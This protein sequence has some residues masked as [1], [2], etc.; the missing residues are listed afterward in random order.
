MTG[1]L[2]NWII[3][4]APK[5]S[6][7]SLF[8]WLVDHPEVGGSYEKE[9][10]YFLDPGAHMFRADSNFRDQGIKG[11]SK[12]FEHCEPSAAVIVESTPAYL[13]SQAALRELPGLPT[14]PSF[15][16]VLREPVSQLRSLFVYF[17]QNWNWIPRAMTFRE[18]ISAV[19]ERRSDFAGNELA[20]NALDNAWYSRHLLRWQQAV[21]ADRMLILLFEDLVTDSRRA[22][23][24]LAVRLGIDPSFYD[25]YAFEPEN[26]SYVA[27]SAMLQDLNIRIREY[28]PK[29]RLYEM[30]RSLYRAANTRRPNGDHSDPDLDRDLAEHYSP[31]LVEL[32]QEFSLNLGKWRAATGAAPP[33]AKQDKSAPHGLPFALSTS[34]GRG[35]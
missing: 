10:C 25:T 15:I 35:R 27:R 14:K 26:T 20:A 7:T 12:L 28:L 8:K 4:G 9:T 23:R 21:G 32:E 5:S 2:P 31:M 11:Y 16:F 19:A 30:A 13:Y 24:Q 3:A 33:A 22:M 6:T 17:Q 1:R 18:F 29:G 34:S